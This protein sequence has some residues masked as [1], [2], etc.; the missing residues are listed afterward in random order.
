[1]DCVFL[2]ISFPAWL[3]SRFRSPIQG[4]PAHRMESLPPRGG[5]W[6]PGSPTE[7]KCDNPCLSCRRSLSHPAFRLKASAKFV[8]LW[9]VRHVAPL[10]CL[11]PVV[12]VLSFFIPSPF[13]LL[14]FLPFFHPTHSFSLHI[15]LSIIFT[16]KALV[17][18][19]GII[20]FLLPHTRRS[21][22]FTT[23]FVFTN[24]PFLILLF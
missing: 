12:G 13:P 21:L 20:G 6:D 18:F 3:A 4:R 11:F 24:T 2:I 7:L 5:I 16:E 8:R 9:R 22:L 17:C 15:C 1:M 19:P 10:S 23:L 14:T